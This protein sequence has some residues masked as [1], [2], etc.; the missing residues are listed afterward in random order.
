[1]QKSFN[2]FN[3]L[4]K[5]FLFLFF[6]TIA[7]LKSAPNPYVSAEKKLRESK[8]EELLMLY[9]QR[10]I[11]PED[12]E[13]ALQGLRPAG[14]TYPKE[15]I[16]NEHGKPYYAYGVKEFEAYVSAIEYIQKHCQGRLP[17]IEDY[18]EVHKLAFGFPGSFDRAHRA[19]ATQLEKDADRERALTLFNSNKSDLAVEEGLL[20]NLL[21]SLRT[22]KKS[23]Y[24]YYPYYGSKFKHEVTPQGLANLR[25]NPRLKIEILDQTADG[26]SVISIAYPPGDEVEKLLTQQFEIL[27]IETSKPRLGLKRKS[28]LGGEFYLGLVEIHGLYDGNGRTSKLM[29]DW[30]LWN[31]GLNAPSSTPSQ[32]LTMTRE[33]YAKSLEAGI[34]DTEKRLKKIAK[35]AGCALALTQ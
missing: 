19:I 29:R 9:G 30:V 11:D 6:I 25:T 8:N 22:G 12:W 14:D 16:P 23:Y 17:T 28:S 1:M 34:L 24:Y 13:K 26:N 7:S 4:K 27:N 15:Y 35:E 20:P 31:Q 2:D 18:L 5:S 3:I 10:F 32:D 21:G 33:E